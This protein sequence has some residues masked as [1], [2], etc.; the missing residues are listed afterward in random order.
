MNF[1]PVISSVAGPN[2]LYK[3]DLFKESLTW[4][5]FI[6]GSRIVTSAFIIISVHIDAEL[7]ICVVLVALSQN[8]PHKDLQFRQLPRLP[9]GFFCS[10]VAMA[11][12]LLI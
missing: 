2:K 4:L 7:R 8:L 5:A 3:C 1:F 12:S 6:A 9:L 11:T 10:L